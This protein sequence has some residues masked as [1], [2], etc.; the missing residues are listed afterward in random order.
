[1][2]RPTDDFWFATI[3]VFLEA[4][5]YAHVELV[6]NWRGRIHGDT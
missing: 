3:I 5:R 6:A 1:V 4:A 2:L